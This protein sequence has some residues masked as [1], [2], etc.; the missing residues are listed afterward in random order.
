MDILP[1]ADMGIIATASLDSN[2][3]LW[4]METLQGKMTLRDHQK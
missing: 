1:I 4:S 3:C 2:I